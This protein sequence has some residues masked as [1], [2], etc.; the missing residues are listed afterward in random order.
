MKFVQ[1]TWTV[2]VVLAACAWANATQAQ[3]L[4]LELTCVGNNTATFTPGLTLTSQTT[5]IHAEGA[6]TACVSTSEPAITSGT[7]VADGTGMLSC[8][9]GGHA[10]SYTIHWNTGESSTIAFTNSIA[11]RPLGE[12]IVVAEGSV[13]GGKFLGRNFT[14]TFTLVQVNLLNCL[15][16]GVPQ[17]TGP[18]TLLLTTP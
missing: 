3:A 18:T 14:G 12:S 10:G 7:Y 15:S 13:T 2:V 16:S 17:A 5:A 8:L 1:H 9:S 4:P 11:F 6:Y